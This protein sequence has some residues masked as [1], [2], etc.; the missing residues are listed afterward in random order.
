MCQ[1]TAVCLGGL[2]RSMIDTVPALTVLTLL[3][4]CRGVCSTHASSFVCGV[5]ILASFYT[6]CINKSPRQRELPIP[7]WVLMG[8]LVTNWNASNKYSQKC[9]QL[10]MTHLGGCSTEFSHMLQN[11]EFGKNKVTPTDLQGGKSNGIL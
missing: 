10:L 1:C 8:Y 9:I 11:K 5:R 6:V 2:M 7:V 4:D 3:S